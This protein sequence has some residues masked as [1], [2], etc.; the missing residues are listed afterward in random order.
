MLLHLADPPP[1]AMPPVVRQPLLG[2]GPFREVRVLEEQLPHPETALPLTLPVS[3]VLP[4][5]AK[6]LGHLLLAHPS[7]LSHSFLCLGQCVCYSSHRSPCLKKLGSSA[8]LR[9][10][11]YYDIKRLVLVAST[12]W[13]I[14]GHRLCIANFQELRHGEVRRINLSRLSENPQARASLLTMSGVI[15][16]WMKVSPVEHTLS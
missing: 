9:P 7:S 5:V 1:V 13:S 16:A 10:K 6:L 11:R 14:I 3:R 2:T 15:A 8:P 12:K 4:P